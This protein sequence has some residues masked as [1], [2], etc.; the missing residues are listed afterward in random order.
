MN[1]FSLLVKRYRTQKNN[2]IQFQ[3]LLMICWR[4]NEEFIDWILLSRIFIWPTAR[5]V[6]LSL[7]LSLWSTI[8]QSRVRCRDKK[9]ERKREQER[10]RKNNYSAIILTTNQNT[11]TDIYVR[12]Y[13]RVYHFSKLLDPVHILILK[14]K[15]ETKQN[16][17]RSFC[18]LYI[19]NTY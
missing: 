5:V 9:G 13:I 2:T 1:L 17:C 19:T 8:R 7:S 3:F 10:E 16:A 18:T 12:T 14:K 15:N 11:Y 6:H 4:A